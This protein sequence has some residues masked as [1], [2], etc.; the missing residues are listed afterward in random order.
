M[1][2]IKIQSSKDPLIA[3]VP[4]L[5]ESAFP[6]AER[7]VTERVVWMID[8]CQVMSF[9]ASTEDGD[10]CGMAVVFE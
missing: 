1:N 10:F 4:E 9:Y 3:Q 5:Y 8:D 2:L 6:E 7:T